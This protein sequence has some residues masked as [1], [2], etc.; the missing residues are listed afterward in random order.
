MNEEE[1]LSRRKK[2][3]EKKAAKNWF[4]KIFS[5]NKQRKENAAQFNQGDTAEFN[6]TPTE[7]EHLSRR[8]IRK[9]RAV[10]GD[11]EKRK[12]LGKRLDVVII[13]LVVLIIAVYLFMRF[14][15]F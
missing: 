8:K 4:K 12:R 3:S 2:A 15:N 10:N 1:N 13:I 7:Q 14:V 11:E 9:D 6:S 5:R